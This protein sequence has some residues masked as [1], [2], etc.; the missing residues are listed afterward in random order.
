MAAA[1]D[2]RTIGARVVCFGAPAS[3]SAK[4]D[5]A[6]RAGPAE[7]AASRGRVTDTHDYQTVAG[8]TADGGFVAAERAEIDETGRRGPAECMLSDR[9]C[10]YRS[11]ATHAGGRRSGAWRTIKQNHAGRGRPAERA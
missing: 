8:E 1:D 10:D 11:V 4:V 5:Q 3:Q 2:D 7:G 9:S 6:R